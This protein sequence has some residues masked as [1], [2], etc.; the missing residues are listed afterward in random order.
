VRLGVVFLA[1]AVLLA[2]CGQARRAGPT[3]PGNTTQA[4]SR[5]YAQPHAGQRP[6]GSAPTDH[7]LSTPRPAHGGQPVP[8]ELEPLPAASFDKPIASYRRYARRQ[9]AAVMSA[10][11]QL[12]RHAAAG[13]IPRARRTWVRAYA[14][15]QRVGGAYG[16]FGALG[17]AID[18]LP[19]GLPRGARDKRFGG[20]HR[21]ER[22]LWSENPTAAAAEAGRLG[23]RLARLRDAGL[24]RAPLDAKDYALRAHEILEDALRDQLSGRAVPQSGAGVAATA[25][26]LDATTELLQTLRPLL[27]GRG[28]ALGPVD[29]ML[30]RLGKQLASI[31]RNHH[32]W[33]ANAALSNAERLALNARM[34][35]ALAALSAVPGT[36][37]TRLTTPPPPISAATR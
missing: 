33:P 4:G 30:P 17:D 6:Y 16:A 37:E 11:A 8:D 27:Q 19:G 28:G 26:A 2:G 10:V 3:A 24:R 23:Q 29:T 14:A 34:Q 7:Q 12:R 35:G 5:T 13:D 15:Y 21:I 1:I 31:H 36:L 32:G 9:L 22:E 25:G 18:G 20:F